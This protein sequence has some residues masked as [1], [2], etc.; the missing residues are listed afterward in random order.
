M[1]W[2]DNKWSQHVKRTA[3]KKIGL[4]QHRH[5]RSC[6]RGVRPLNAL[7][8]P[9][10][11]ESLH[12]CL[13]KSTVSRLPSKTSTALCFSSPGTQRLPRNYILT[14]RWTGCPRSPHLHTAWARPP[15]SD[16]RTAPDKHLLTHILT[17]HRKSNVIVGMALCRAGHLMANLKQV[18]VFGSH[19]ACWSSRGEGVTG[20]QAP[21]CSHLGL[22][23]SVSPGLV[24]STASA[25]SARVTDHR[26]P[27]WTVA[28]QKEILIR[29]IKLLCG[30]CFINE[31]AGLIKCLKVIDST[32]FSL[33]CFTIYSCTP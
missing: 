18:V 33:S 24:S 5:L 4:C 11:Q 12:N 15:R 30:A 14:A 16:P 1:F 21:A 8:W 9:A 27:C 2:T 20:I 22:H 3:K 13:L 19:G 17:W 26:D 25:T 6:L 23:Q 28:E 10:M 7:I 32:G 31:E 29:G